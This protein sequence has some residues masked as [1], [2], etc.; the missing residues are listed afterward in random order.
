MP[1]SSN[2]I[3][4]PNFI[5]NTAVAEVLSEIADRL[6][7]ASDVE[8]EAKAIIKEYITKHNRI[9]FNGDN[10]SEDWVKEAEKRG[11]PNITNMV[12]A[13]K[14]LIDEKNV[15]IFVKHG[16]LSEVECHSRYD[17]LLENYIN[18]INIEARTSLEMVKRDYIPSII[19]FVSDLAASINA[20]KACG[21]AAN[22]EV[23]EELLKNI[24]DLLAVANK[25]VK[26]LEGVLEKAS[27]CDNVAEKAGMYRDEVFSSM[28]SLRC[29]IDML[30][31]MVDSKYWP[32]PTYSD[33]L[34][35]VK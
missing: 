28:T 17:I 16:V 19:K 20:V 35:G 13:K 18:T 23:Q 26:V 1:P 31:T 29:E 5:I 22:L 11:L 30:E 24:S 6:E 9:I 4:G 33:L 27:E 2:S 15:S 10:Y 32:F 8:A 34:F 14:A 7:A 12:D 21:V 3:A 25:K